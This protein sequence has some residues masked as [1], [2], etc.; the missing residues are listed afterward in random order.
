MENVT[1]PPTYTPEQKLA[2]KAK[3][4][5]EF[6]KW[7][8]RWPGS[9]ADPDK[10]RDYEK[11]VEPHYK[12]W[13]A[14]DPAPVSTEPD[15]KIRRQH[16]EDQRGLKS[17]LVTQTEEGSPDAKAVIEDIIQEHADFTAKRPAQPKPGEITWSDVERAPSLQRWSA[18]H[19]RE[20]V[21]RM[22]GVGVTPQ[23]SI[24]VGAAVQDFR[25]LRPWDNPPAEYDEATR[26]KA[27]R[28]LA[29]FERGCPVAQ[30]L[31]GCVT[32]EHAAEIEEE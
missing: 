30:T 24:L 20:L 4:D 14:E 29:V 16:R 26:T 21:Q 19:R 1:T 7:L 15:W 6:Q 17:E 13:H 25:E 23:E 5:E 2:A 31:K 3:G 12:I 11:N 22:K 28:A 9:S 10:V 18:D 32:L 27:E 8:G